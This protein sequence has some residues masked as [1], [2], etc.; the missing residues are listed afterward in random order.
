MLQLV[1]TDTS[2]NLTPQALLDVCEREFGLERRGALA[3]LREVL[4]VPEPDSAPRF[5]NARIRKIKLISPA[6]TKKGRERIEIQYELPTLDD[7]WETGSKASSDEARPEFYQALEKLVPH[8]CV[9]CEF[10]RNYGEDDGDQ[11]TMLVRGVTFSFLDDPDQTMGVV[12]SAQKKLVTSKS[13]FNFSTPLKYEHPSGNGN[14][15][16]DCF[17]PEMGK[18]LQ[19]VIREARRYLA[20]DR[21]QGSFL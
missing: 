16:S 10:D 8:V 2:P 12:L 15:D 5:E 9:I 17:D 20:G 21:A 19:Q 18:A 6:K 14:D 4:D 7:D 1:S 11:H 3:R 13:P